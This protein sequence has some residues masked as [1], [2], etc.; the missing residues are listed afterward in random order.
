M[1]VIEK[2]LIED[3]LR[4]AFL[5]LVISDYMYSAGESYILK[6]LE[7]SSSLALAES[8]SKTLYESNFYDEKLALEAYRKVYSARDGPDGLDTLST[9][10][11]FEDFKIKFQ[12]KFN[13]GFDGIFE[14]YPTKKFYE[15]TGVFHR[16][17]I[18][19][20]SS[21]L[22]D[23]IIDTWLFDPYIETFE[24][25]YLFFIIL[26]ILVNFGKEKLLNMISI[27]NSTKMRRIINDVLKSDDIKLR[28]T[29]RFDR[30]EFCVLGTILGAMRGYSDLLKDSVIRY[31]LFLIDSIIL[32][33]DIVS[34]FLKKII[35]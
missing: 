9:H 10:G 21:S 27:D 29:S 1:D 5:G 15:R 31:N 19:L 25:V 35:N 17:V 4:G 33:D 8:L 32:D 2:S 7:P 12:A 16:A 13:V 18:L 3:R 26:R 34:N 14:D 22:D 28:Y 6:S 23:F 20:Q 30:E 24:E 11:N